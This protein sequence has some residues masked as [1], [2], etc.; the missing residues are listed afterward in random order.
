VDGPVLKANQAL[1]RSIPQECKQNLKEAMGPY[2]FKGWTMDDLTP[3]MTRR[4]QVRALMSIRTVCERVDLVGSHT[5]EVETPL[6]SNSPHDHMILRGT[7][8]THTGGGNAL[9][10]KPRGPPTRQADPFLVEYH[11][12]AMAD[13]LAQR[14]AANGRG[15]AWCRW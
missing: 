7:W 4:A 1:V 15:A 9:A 3:N 2:G 10:F 5:G 13:R 12:R 11:Y 14:P 6:P 8:W